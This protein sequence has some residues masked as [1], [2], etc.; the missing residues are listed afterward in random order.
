VI[1]A[2]GLCRSGDRA[3]CFQ[4]GGAG[5]EAMRGPRMAR[6]SPAAPDETAARILTPPS[7]ELDSSW[8]TPLPAVLSAQA[9]WHVAAEYSRLRSLTPECRAPS[10]LGSLRGQRRSG[11]CARAYE[12]PSNLLR[13]N[14]L[15]GCALF[16]PITMSSPGWSRCGLKAVETGRPPTHKRSDALGW[17]TRR[18]AISTS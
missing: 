1:V 11:G 12:T 4:H 14:R 5:D 2:P 18:P 15:L 7:P 16:A 3:A 9:I 10:L 17:R 8:S 13:L 6:R